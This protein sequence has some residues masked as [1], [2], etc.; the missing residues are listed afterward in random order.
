VVKI[1]LLQVMGMIEKAEAEYQ[2]L[3]HKKQVIENDKKKIENVRV[4]PCSNV[5]PGAYCS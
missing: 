3:I 4:V 5:S 2:D 1:S